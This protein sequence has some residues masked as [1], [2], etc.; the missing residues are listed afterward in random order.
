[1]HAP[2][3]ASRLSLLALSVPD[4]LNQNS[5]TRIQQEND[6]KRAFEDKKPLKAEVGEKGG[7]FGRKHRKLLR[8]RRN[9]AREHQKP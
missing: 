1:M 9:R 4:A 3:V 8:E 7:S 6:V 2:S 5:L